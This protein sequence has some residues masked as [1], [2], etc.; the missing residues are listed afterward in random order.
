[1]EFYDDD[2]N[3]A[4]S[5]ICS[6]NISAAGNTHISIYPNPASGGRFYI[7]TAGTDQLLV[8]IYTSTG[9]LLLHTTL[10]GQTQYPVQLPS[11]PLSLSAVVVQTIYQNNTRSF[12]LLV[13]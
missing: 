10:Q 5:S 9:Q 6:V 7:T 13:R 2:G 12:T 1:M 11:Q 3:T 8:N 4:Y